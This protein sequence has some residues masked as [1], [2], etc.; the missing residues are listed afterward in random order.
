MKIFLNYQNFLYDNT[1]KINMF[2]KNF[3]A[4]LK[5]SILFMFLLITIIN[6][7]SPIIIFS[8]QHLNIEDYYT[9]LLIQLLFH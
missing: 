4:I 1:F 7:Y 5:H 8:L 6:I 3:L 2:N 9:I